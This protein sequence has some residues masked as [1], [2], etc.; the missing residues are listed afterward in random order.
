M[1]SAEILASQDLQFDFPSNLLL[2]FLTD[3]AVINGIEMR[4]IRIR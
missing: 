3:I 2:E 1:P 4:R